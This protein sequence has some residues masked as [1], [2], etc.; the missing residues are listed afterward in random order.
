MFLGIGS[1]GAG[2]RGA[3]ISPPP[4]PELKDDIFDSPF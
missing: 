3:C 1:S 2:G 4:N